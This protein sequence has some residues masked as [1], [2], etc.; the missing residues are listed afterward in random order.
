MAI[1]DKIYN[2]IPAKSVATKSLTI[3][4]VGT[5]YMSQYGLQPRVGF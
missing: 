4:L 5:G 1:N 3:G 2:L